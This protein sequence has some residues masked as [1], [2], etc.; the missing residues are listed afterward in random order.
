MSEKDLKIIND[1]AKKEL[2]R[3]NKMTK[4]EARQRLAD[5]GIFDTSGKYTAPYKN[6]A[7]AVKNR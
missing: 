4:K 3:A 7:A 6:L 2:K 5:A 1:L